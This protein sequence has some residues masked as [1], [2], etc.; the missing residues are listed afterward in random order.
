MILPGGNFEALR[1]AAVNN[2]TFRVAFDLGNWALTSKGATVSSTTALSADWPA[3]G[4]IDGDRTH[5][6]AGPAASADNGIGQS[7]WQGGTTANGAGVLP[8]NEDI[9]ITLA[10]PT[11]INRITMYWWPSGTKT[12]PLPGTQAKDFSVY[13]STDG[14]NYSLWAALTDK[15]SEIG[16][17]GGGT[18]SGGAMTGNDQ[19][20]NVF[21]D[22]TGKTI[23]NI[24]IRITKLQAGSVNPVMV[25]LEMCRTIDCTADVA[26][27][28]RQR[29]KDYAL[30]NRLAAVVNLTLRNPD[31]KYGPNY[32]P[33]AAELAAGYFNEE[34]RPSLELRVFGGFSG[35]NVQMFRGYIDGWYPNA[36]TRTVKVRSRDFIKYLIKNNVKL[37]LRAGQTLE[38]NA[39]YTANKKNFPSNLMVLDQT[40]LTVGFFM[41]NEDTPLNIIQ[42]LGGATGDAELYFDEYGRMNFRSYLNVVS[43]IQ[44]WAD[45]AAFQAGTNTNTDSTTVPGEIDLAKVGGNYVAEGTWTSG[46]S[47]LLPLLIEYV[48]FDVTATTDAYTSIDWFI[49]VS[50]DGGTTVTP[51]R[52][53][54]P[55]GIMSR[56]NHGWAYVQVQARLRSSNTSHTPKVYSAVVH[57]RSRAGSIKYPSAAV[58]TV[59]YNSTMRDLSGSITDEVGGQNLMI[60]DAIVKAKPTFL[61]SGT[62]TAWQGTVND[63]IVSSSNPMK[64]PLGNT[65]IVV[66]YGDTQFNTPQTVNITWGT[67]AGTATLSNHPS[68]PT[69]TINVTTA[70]TVTALTISGT[71][72]VQG[73]AVQAEAMAAAEIVDDYGDLTDTYANDYITNID[74]ANDIANGRIRLFSAPIDYQQE[75]PMQFFPNVQINDRGTV[76]ELNSGTDKDYYVIGATDDIVVSADMSAQAETK[77]EA[78]GIGVNDLTPQPA[79]WGSA[80][81]WYFDNF[82]FGGQR[83]L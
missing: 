23:T 41:P 64:L 38:A 13:Y 21:E 43:N 65:V 25:A 51:W 42:Q 9:I 56:W 62:E 75:I 50:S 22:S 27:I 58:F 49:R 20:A 17:P 72:F 73:G 74:L 46:W 45:A 70:G 24:K 67:A 54:D 19:D 16:K 35:T 53:V 83:G 80:G 18:L 76:V 7:V 15:G 14:V 31:R 61:S 52:Q 71:P 5:I 77:L 57:Y 2:P 48:Q 44:Q 40:A 10:A 81:V 59:K 30:N 11:L 69:L 68:T 37:N 6:N 60:T 63:N 79:Y 8:A 39:E 78:V 12:N 36:L 34:L 4:I 55:P 1:E 33:T 66:D 28:N 32:S 47:A 26:A 82:R 3:S 29:H